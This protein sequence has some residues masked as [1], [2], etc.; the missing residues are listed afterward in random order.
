MSLKIAITGSTGM[1]GRETVAFFRRHGHTVTPFVRKETRFNSPEPVIR[2]DIPSGEVD[3]NNLEGHD[4]I[5][6]LAGANIAA[7]KWTARYKELIRSSRTEGTAVLAT[8][9]AKMKKKPRV[10]LSASA[11]GYYGP[12]NPDVTVDEKAPPAEDF[13]AKV[14]ADWE[15]AA[16]PAVDAGVRT[17]FMRIGTVMGKNGGA[18]GKMLPIFRAGLG[19]VLGSGRQ[20]MSWVAL[21]DLPLMMQHCIERADIKGPVNFV[22]PSAV[23]NREFTGILGKAIARPV[24]F[25]VPSFGLRILYG[26]MADALLLNGARIKPGVLESSGY[27]FRYTNLESALQACLS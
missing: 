9:I 19:G 5:I 20:V 3:L 1:V 11:I 8:A 6:H 15:K 21:A 22:S 12:H 24:I 10:F 16:A 2:W 4:T 23:S 7:G 13:L 25:P 18:L 27:G 26:E 14:C 17:V